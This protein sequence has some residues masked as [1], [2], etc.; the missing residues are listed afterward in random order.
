MY[1]F[2][3]LSAHRCAAVT[4]EFVRMDQY[5]LICPS[6][7][8]LPAMSVEWRKQWCLVDIDTLVRMAEDCFWQPG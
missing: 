3:S 8:H 7:K 2:S 4:W 1:L 6:K 5:N